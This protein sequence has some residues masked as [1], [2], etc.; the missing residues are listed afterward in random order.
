M[1]VGTFQQDIGNGKKVV[2]GARGV[3][4][5]GAVFEQGVGFSEV[6]AHL[7]TPHWQRPEALA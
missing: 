6:S 1:C 3:M 7:P 5:D 4:R 2:E